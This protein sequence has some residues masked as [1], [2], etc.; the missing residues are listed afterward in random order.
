MKLK[1]PGPQRY[2]SESNPEWLPA[3]TGVELREQKPQP[4]LALFPYLWAGR[5]CQEA[6]VLMWAQIDLE[7]GQIHVRRPAYFEPKT[8]ESQRAV[9]LAPDAVEVLRSF[10]RGNDPEFSS[11]VPRPTHRRPTTITTAIALGAT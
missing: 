9:D 10:K 11:T 5:R 4:Y 2:R 1:D 8:E 7:Q 3:C 6:D